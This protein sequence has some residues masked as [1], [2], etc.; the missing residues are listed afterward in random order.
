MHIMAGATP[1]TTLQTKLTRMNAELESK[2][3]VE[4]PVSSQLGWCQDRIQSLEVRLRDYQEPDL[5]TLYQAAQLKAA[6]H[7]RA[8]NIM[9]LAAAGAALATFASAGL[10]SGDAAIIGIGLGT[11][12]TL[13]LGVGIVDQTLR[14]DEALQTAHDVQAW[15]RA[16]SQAPETY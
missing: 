13:G 5:Q 2:G 15:G 3:T 6:G 8:S 12:A 1:R 11:A 7:Q 16:F 9:T 10:M 4:D 14:S